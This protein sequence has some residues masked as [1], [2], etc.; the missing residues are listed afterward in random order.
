ME[1]FGQ[2]KDGELVALRFRDVDT[3]E[4]RIVEQ[5]YETPAPQG[6]KSL[7]GRAYN[8]TMFRNPRKGVQ[9]PLRQREAASGD[10]Y[11]QRRNQGSLAFGMTTSTAPMRWSITTDL[12]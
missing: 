5:F 3:G 1:Y 6:E 11:G 9:L 7:C 2:R 4:E 8:S 10:H 12:L